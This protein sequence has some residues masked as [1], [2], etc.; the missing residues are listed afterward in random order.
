MTTLRF[1]SAW[2]SA[3]RSRIRGDRCRRLP[4]AINAAQI[5]TPELAVVD[6]RLAG[7]S[8]LA[9]VRDLKALDASTVVV[10]LTG[11]GSIATAVES[12][13]LGAGKLPDETGRRGSNRGRVRRDAPV[14]RYASPVIGPGRVGA[15]PEDPRRLRR[16]RF[17]RGSRI[18]D[19]SAIPP[20]KASEATGFAVT[21][22][23]GEHHPCQPR[24]NLLTQGHPSGL[25][26]KT[27]QMTDLAT[28][29]RGRKSFE[30]RAWAD[31]YRLLQAADRDAPLDAEDLE[32][33]ATASYLMG[34]EDESENF[35]ERAHHAFL[36][37]GDREG[38]ARSACWLAVGLQLRGA[39]APASGW[40]A[41]AQRILDDGQIE[42]VVRGFLLIPTAIQRIV[43]GDPAAGD[44]LFS[45][46]AEI[47]R[48]YGDRDLACKASQGRG[49]ALIRLGRVREGVALLDEAMV[50]VIAGEVSPMLA[51]DAYCTVLEGCQEIFDLRR[52]YEWTTS[53]TRWCATQPDLVRYRGECLLYRSEVMQLRG[54]WQDAAQDAQDACELLTSRPAAGAAF[55]RLGEIHRLRGEF[56]KAEAAYTRANERGR[57]PQ[58]GLSLLRLTQG[59]VEAATAAIRNVL[60][61]TRAQTSRARILAAAVDIL[62]TAGDLEQ[63]RA[64]A[65]ELS[66]DRACA[67]CPAPFRNVRACRRRGPPGGRRCGR[68][69]RRRSA[70]PWRSGGISRCRT[71][72]RNTCVLLAAI[73]EQRGDQDG[74]R[75]ELEAARRRFKQLD[76]APWL[77]RIAEQSERAS[78]SANRLAQRTRDAGAS[79]DGGR[80]DESRDRRRAVHQ[81]ETVARHV[82]NIFDKVHVSSRTAAAAWA[83]HHNLT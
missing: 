81:R 48:R 59:H 66:R 54:R 14:R 12:I 37:R 43:Q 11:Y 82:S 80:Q 50:A 13:K 55:Y 29:H 2:L 39:M 68:R 60:L 62:L 4:S 24:D 44:A 71:K 40:F 1:A 35:W 22:R 70:R 53:L 15:H 7:E 47:A 77:A 16:Q 21:G 75:L 19:P 83:F 78:S 52:A 42:C 74:R 72:R 51:G 36:Q 61:D 6:L 64:A 5:E 8:G 20:T 73:C 58:P 69:V 33:L 31:S 41:R 49:R 34:R 10:V 18:R 45:Q 26:S 38:A 76:A 3:A 63:A 56:A 25:P 67:R 46:A 9:V 32:R 23:E 27:V 30:Q 79:A 17:A 28:L 65:A 57:K